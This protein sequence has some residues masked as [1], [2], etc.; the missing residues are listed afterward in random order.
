MSSTLLPTSPS[1]GPLN[2][3]DCD[4][5]ALGAQPGGWMSPNGFGTSDIGGL[6]IIYVNGVKTMYNT[7]GTFTR[8]L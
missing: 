7:P 6:V 1:T 2:T 5:I 3:A 8:T 4:Y